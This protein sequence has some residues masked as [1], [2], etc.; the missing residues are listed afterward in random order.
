MATA[1]E[2]INFLNENFDVQ[3]T[4]KLDGGGQLIHIN[5]A[6]NDGRSQSVFVGFMGPFVRIDSPVGSVED[7]DIESLVDVVSNNS[8]WGVRKTADMY[9]VTN[10]GILDTVDAPELLIPIN[11][12]AELA[13]ELEKAAFGH[14]QM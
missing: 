10:T 9:C 13:D 5:V 7:V 8:V 12:I 4:K 6:W 3:S 2:V 11:Q 1:N 14:D